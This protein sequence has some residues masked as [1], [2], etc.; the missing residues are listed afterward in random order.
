MASG[1]GKQL[2]SK[3]VRPSAMGPMWELLGSSTRTT[4]VLKEERILTPFAKRAHS[5]SLLVR[6]IRVPIRSMCWLGME[7]LP[8]K[9]FSQLASLTLSWGLRQLYLSL[10]K[11][12]GPTTTR[13][14]NTRTNEISLSLTFWRQK[15]VSP[16]RAH[17]GVSRSN[18]QCSGGLPRFPFGQL[19]LNRLRGLDR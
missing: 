4:E 8:N 19:P 1:V 14:Y 2:R 18:V 16:A 7:R 12:V 17:R 3:F 10:P 11:S 9:S 15:P 13:G 5:P 6:G